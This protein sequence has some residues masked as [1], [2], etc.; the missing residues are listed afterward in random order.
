[1]RHVVMLEAAVPSAKPFA[2]KWNPAAWFKPHVGP[3][4]GGHFL[5]LP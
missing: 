4:C 3:N 5:F 1:M 2:H